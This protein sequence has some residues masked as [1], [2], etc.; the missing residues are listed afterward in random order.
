MSIFERFRQ[1]ICRSD[2]VTDAA[3]KDPLRL[4]TAAI[5]L[6]IGYADGTLS[7]SEDD[8]LLSYLKEKFALTEEHAR[9]LVMAADQIR[10][11]QIDHYSLTNLIRKSASLAER[12]EI[13]KTMWRMVYSDGKLTENENHLVRKLADLLGIEHHVMIDA[14]VS[15]LQEIGQTPA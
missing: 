8:G 1:G 5:L 13:V 6:D 3:S 4:A 12:I 7:P 11:R 14:K 2:N 9:E 15:V 10:G